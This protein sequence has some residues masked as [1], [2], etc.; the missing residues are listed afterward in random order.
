MQKVNNNHISNWWRLYKLHIH[1]VVLSNQSVDLENV[2]Y[3][4]NNVFCKILIYLIPLSLIA[5]LPSVY[6]AFTHDVPLVGFMDLLAFLMVLILAVLPGIN[7]AYRK[8][9]FIFIL[10]CLSIVLL[11]SLPLPGPGLIFLLTITIF[12]SLIYSSSAAYVSAWCNTIIC[13]CFVALI[14][15]GTTSVVFSGYTIG[16]WIAV[17]SNLVLVSFTCAK[18]LD[19]LLAGLT[20]ALKEN[21]N[22]AAKLEKANRLYQFISQINQTIVHVKDAETLFHKSCSIAIEYGQYKKAWISTF[23]REHQKILLVDSCGICPDEIKSFTDVPYETNGSMDYVL[24]TGNYFLCNDIEQEHEI[25]SWKPFAEKHNI[26]SCILLPIKRGGKIFGTFNLYATESNYFD[27]DDIASL[28][29]VTG[30]I[31]FALDLFDKTEKHNQAEELIIK[32]EKRFRALIEDGSDM[33][34]LTTLEGKIIYGSPSVPKLFGYTIEEVLNTSAY[35]LI[36]PEDITEL[37]EQIR[38][39]VE[40]PGKSFVNQHRILHKNQQWIWCEGTF[41]NMLHEPGIEALVSNFRDISEKKEAEIKLQKNFADLEALSKE[42]S[43]I[44]NTLPASIALLDQEGTIVKLNDEWINFGL[45]NGM[46]NTYQQLGKNY[47]EISEKSLGREAKDGKQMSKGLQEVLR[48]E[49]EYF[50]MEYQCDSATEKRWFKAEVR[51]FKT[52]NHTGAVVMHINIS[53]RKK[54][55][56]EML[57]LIN[58]TEESFLLLN[59]NLQI[60][61]FNAQ[62][63]NLYEKYFQLKVQKGHYILDYTLPERREYVASIYQKVLEGNAEESEL[64]FKDADNS[65]LYFCLKYNPAKD[66]SGSIFGVFVTASDITEKR[67]AEEQK[68]FE[69]R[70]KEA[71]I[72]STDDLIWSVS[73]DFKLIAANNPFINELKKITNV[74]IQQGD[75]FFT[76]GLYPEDYLNYWKNLYTRAFTGESFKVEIY[77]PPLA[78]RDES[79]TETSFSPIFINDKIFGIACYSRNMTERK[80]SELELRASETRLA[81]AQS[82]AK[83]GNWETDLV[84]LNVLWSEETYRIFDCKPDD[85]SFTHPDFLNYVHPDDRE[86]VE[87]AFKNSFDSFDVNTVEH[88]IITQKG[89]IKFLEE[90]WQLIRNTE[91]IPIKAV[92]TCQDISERKKSDHENKFKAELLDTIGQSVIATD[93]DGKVTFWNK[94]AVEIYGYTFEEAFG[95]NIMELTPTI[96]T[97][98][99]GEKIMEK[100]AQ[101]ETWSGEFYVRRKTGSFFPA[102]VYNSPVYDEFGKQIGII[103]VSNDISERKE[104]ELERAKITS[105]LLQRN[106]DLEQFT[107]II[108]HN[109]RAPTANIIG[110]T[111]ILQDD[112]LSQSEQKEMLY[113]L[114][115]SV[116]GLDSIIKDINSILQIRR[117]INE[118]KE[119]ISFTKLVNDIMANIENVIDKNKVQ[120]NVDFTEVDE[121][122]SLKVYMHS[123]FYNLISNSIKYNKPDEDSIIEISSK[124]DNGK[125]ILIFRDNGLGI[126]LKTKGDKV[127]GLYKRFHSHVEGKGLGLFMVK[128]QVEAM[129]GIIT[130]SSEV[131]KGTEFTIIFDN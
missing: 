102:F 130:I 13:I 75:S 78:A 5:L 64:T 29:E 62:F 56:A 47:I 10:Y 15:F 54:A 6:M 66:E 105:D 88:R 17:S 109:L 101:G 38:S 61:S 50:T 24:Q 48:G 86:K 33:I 2:D 83:I 22:Y 85:F 51:P 114:S 37:V 128:T 117:E 110:F 119:I 118:K 71:L 43:T 90:R 23:D 112:S 120:I 111:E 67:R 42:Q 115:S 18:C 82:I 81:E 52:N 124:R 21:R 65:M 70:N 8:A 116:S 57:L 7:L 108:S 53:E 12:S 49:R 4:R 106:R 25:A 69:R 97:K 91:G 73:T 131:N 123:I 113:G 26:G 27:D 84:N 20:N 122:F 46:P 100:L 125:I 68:E 76:E 45:A 14:Y 31:S 34:T 16:S 94:A 77:T 41:T 107:F 96:Q 63:K 32:N 103:G 99:D 127:F 58:N 9:L 72:N 1:K 98:A 3:W 19:L 129:G 28:I 44:L 92:G 40:I 60:V 30:D 55:E 39:V 126:D 104:Y 87:A 74:E 89:E 79:W 11:I 121:Y 93:L 35:D 95:K 59:S 80:K 36:H